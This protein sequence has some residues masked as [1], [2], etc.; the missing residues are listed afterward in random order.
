MHANPLSLKVNL[1]DSTDEDSR[2]Y[3]SQGCHPYINTASPLEKISLMAPTY[4]Y[5]EI[6]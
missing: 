3:Q 5:A 1:K 2:A 6:Y 4:I